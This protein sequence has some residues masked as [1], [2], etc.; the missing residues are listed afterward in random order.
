MSIVLAT[1]VIIA[2]L[3]FVRRNEQRLEAEVERA[4]PGP[5]DGYL[6][7]GGEGQAAQQNGR[8]SRSSQGKP[9]PTSSAS[10]T[11][12]TTLEGQRAE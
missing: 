2:F 4:L 7:K 1:L 11:H 8:P 3:I 5:L 10:H 9:A 12:E 6:P